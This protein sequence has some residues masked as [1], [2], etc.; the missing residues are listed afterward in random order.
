MG[1]GSVTYTT[2]VSRNGIVDP[3]A[4]K[5]ETILWA[6]QR[7]LDHRW[8]KLGKELA[9]ILLVA[10]DATQLGGRGAGADI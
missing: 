6:L 8:G 9:S 10:C 1:D 5:G 2:L 3:S 4:A 7:K